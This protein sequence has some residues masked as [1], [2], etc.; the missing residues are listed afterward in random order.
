MQTIGE[1]T[2]P[3]WLAPLVAG[4]SAACG[5]GCGGAAPLVATGGGGAVVPAGSRAT[6]ILVSPTA[7]SIS[8]KPVSD[9]SPASVRITAAS[10]AGGGRRPPILTAGPR[11]VPPR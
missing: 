11:P 5:C 7:Y 8:V 2:A 6:R 9:R 4:F 10:G 1:V 3:G